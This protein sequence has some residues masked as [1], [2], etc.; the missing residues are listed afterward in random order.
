MFLCCIA[1]I[2]VMLIGFLMGFERVQLLIS[3]LIIVIYG[4]FLI[5]DTKIICGKINSSEKH[6]NVEFDYDD[7][8]IGAL[9]L[10]IDIIMI[11]LH[12]LRTLGNKWTK[13]SI[14]LFEKLKKFYLWWNIL[15]IKLKYLNELLA[16][17]IINFFFIL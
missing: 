13:I 9:M 8:V 6:N 7:Y 4:L 17:I 3:A 2:P 14:Y 11:F 5:Y 12:I 1:L 10:Y 15:Q 16:I